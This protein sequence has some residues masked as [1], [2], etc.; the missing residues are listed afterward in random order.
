MKR[1]YNSV[2]R[3]RINVRQSSMRHRAVD[4]AR[5]KLLS[6]HTDQTQ[7]GV[8]RTALERYSDQLGLEPGIAELTAA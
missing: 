4:V 2:G 1:K 7:A 3:P 6:I 8:I 5:L